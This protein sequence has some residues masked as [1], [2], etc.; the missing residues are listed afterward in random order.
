[1]GHRCEGWVRP[2]D[3]Q[4][5]WKQARLHNR[6]PVPED[7]KVLQ[8]GTRSQTCR[9]VVGLERALNHT[10][11]HHSDQR[12]DIVTGKHSRLQQAQSITQGHCHSGVEE[13]GRS[14][15]EA[16]CCSNLPSLA[17]I[18]HSGQTPHSTEGQGRTHGWSHQD[19]ETVQNTRNLGYSQAVGTPQE[20]AQDHTHA[21][22]RLC[23]DLDK[24]VRW[25]RQRYC[26]RL[27]LLLRSSG[28][29]SGSLALALALRPFRL[30]S[31]W[32]LGCRR[33]AVLDGGGSGS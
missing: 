12:R 32:L 21:L 10:V 31:R 7:T 25:R 2:C 19:V 23:I 6:F 14:C 27:L 11:C 16:A 5:N 24:R 26:H 13:Y 1:M 28:R 4:Q 20:L 9:N 8:D 29:S 22:Q 17:A 33:V 15:V 18:N 3:I 30:L